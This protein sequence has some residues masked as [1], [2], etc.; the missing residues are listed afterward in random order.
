MMASQSY[1][2]WQ[3]VA[4]L[5]LVA[6]LNYADRLM[7][8][9]LRDPLKADIAMSDAQ[10]GLLTSVFLWAYGIFSP[11]GGFLADKFGRS[12]LITASLAVWS[13]ATWATGHLST[14]DAL[15]F[16]RVV[17]GVSQAFYMPAALA[18]ISDYH[19]ST[20][21]SLATGVHTSGVYAGAAFGGVGAIVAESFGWRAGFQWFG[22]FGVFYAMILALFLRD[23]R[24]GESGSDH[25][26]AGGAVSGRA[27][28]RA[29]AGQPFFWVV[30]AVASLVGLANWAVYGWLPTYLRERFAMG[31]GSSGMT[32]TGVIQLASFGGVLVGGVWADRWSRRQP[33][34]RALVP[35]L[36]FCAAAPVLF[37]SL[38]SSLLAVSLMGFAF[39]GVSR[40][41]VD[42]NL[43]PV[44][45]TVVDERYS[46]TG[47][48][49]LNFLSVSLGGILIYVAGWLRDKNVPLMI[50]Y[51]FAS[52]CLLV[53]GCLLLTLKPTRGDAGAGVAKRG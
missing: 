2:A 53:A 10:F 33:R 18:L 9:T 48:G 42:A 51:Q 29:L 16:S 14:L 39:Y 15:L 19:P 49:V 34:A 27:A 38:D 50:I 36:G 52:A 3:C 1:R 25:P 46:A 5:W 23:V 26:V 43:M 4:L 17:M 13:A 11:L 12:I 24:R 6:L 35:A 32:A 37:L 31:L 30:L 7:I 8:T 21:R 44:L 40:G 28:I 45:R 47:F 20:T 22:V 41:L